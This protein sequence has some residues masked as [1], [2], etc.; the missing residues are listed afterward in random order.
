[1]SKLLDREVP[2][3]S[4]DVPQVETSAVLVI[5]QEPQNLVT[6]AQAAVQRSLEASVYGSTVVD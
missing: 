4:K 6:P 5:K 1:M 3:N 2:K